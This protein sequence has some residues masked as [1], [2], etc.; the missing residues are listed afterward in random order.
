MTGILK[1]L[2]NVCGYK[3]S[4]TKTVRDHKDFSILYC[5]CKNPKCN[6]SF[7]MNL[8]FGHTTK[9][10]LLMKDELLLAMI[11]NLSAENR[12]LMLNRLTKNTEE[13]GS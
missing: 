1:I 13:K 5:S 7:T 10:S 2:C 4:I 3:A 11:D 8:E 6:H 9:S 12:Q